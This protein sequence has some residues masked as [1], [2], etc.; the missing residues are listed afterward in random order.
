MML[1]IFLI[2]ATL[3][4][5]YRIWVRMPLPTVAGY[6]QGPGIALGQG[7]LIITLLASS[8]DYGDFARIS[9]VYQTGVLE[10]RE[11]LFFVLSYC[12]IAWV[13][14]PRIKPATEDL[15]MPD[16]MRRF[17]GN[18]AALLTACVNAGTAILLLAS[19]IQAMGK[20][21]SHAIGSDLLPV[22]WGIGIFLAI[23]SAS[24]DMWSVMEGQWSLY[25]VYS[26]ILVALTITLLVKAGGMNLFSHLP[27]EKLAIIGHPELLYKLK[28][29]VFW[30]LMPTFLLSPPLVQRLFIAKRTANPSRVFL[31]TGLIYGCISILFMVIGL[32]AWVLL[33]GEELPEG[34]DLLPLLFEKLL[35]SSFSSVA[36]KLWLGVVLALFCTADA[37]L[38]AAGVSLGRDMLS[39]VLPRRTDE[40]EVRD[41]RLGSIAIGLLATL[42]ATRGE[43]PLGVN[44]YFYAACLSSMAVVPFITGHLGKRLRG[45]SAFW[46]FSLPYLAGCLALWGMYS[47]GQIDKY[48]LWYGGMGA[49]LLG[50]GIRYMVSGQAERPAESPLPNQ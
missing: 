48:T 46:S 15:T 23:Y 10:M 42:L 18:T 2:L 34:T 37:H 38:H 1:P 13:L 30:G 8:V 5:L 9:Y 32:S 31:L 43:D 24:G 36:G 29:G 11:A 22:I 21:V 3:C 35:P 20:Y 16:T 33:K 40:A 45:A 28:S 47:S 4:C 44:S 49:G 26:G 7:A 14:V 27:A 41:M 25:K 17:Y 12:F 39:F 6:V 19:Q 50:L